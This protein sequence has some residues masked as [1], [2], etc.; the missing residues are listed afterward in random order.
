MNTR[1]RLLTEAARLLDAGGE[2]VVTLRAVAQAVG[3][4]HNAPYRHFVDRNDLLAGVVERDLTLLA[5][6][7]EAAR[8]GDGSASERLRRGLA[9]FVDYGCRYPSRY[10]LMFSKPEIV[11]AESALEAAGTA[12]FEAVIGLVQDG[13]KA[14]VLP[15][16]PT[17]ALANLIYA[18]IHGLIDLEI[19]GCVTEQDGLPGSAQG[20][21]LLLN[22]MRQSAKKG[23]GQ[24]EGS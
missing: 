18:T 4:S 19:A 16:T 5:A 10:R 20:I 8:S 13:Q 2:S 15:A 1:E 17:R 3:V 22:L 9:T 11:L 23:Q 24:L 14:G 6:G 12:A 21:S 7:V